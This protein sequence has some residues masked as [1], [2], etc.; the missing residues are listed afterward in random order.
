VYVVLRR[1]ELNALREAKVPL[2]PLRQ[3]P[4]VVGTAGRGIRRQVWG[5]LYV[6]TNVP[7]APPVSE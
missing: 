5:V 1:I 6:A 3:Y 2:Y 7:P 4:A